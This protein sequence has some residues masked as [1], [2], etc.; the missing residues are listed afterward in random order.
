MTKGPPESPLQEPTPPEP[1]V[2]NWLS[3]MMPLYAR[4]Q[5][6]LLITST[7]TSRKTGL[8]DFEESDS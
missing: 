7:S 8:A 5:C 3:W 1:E 6:N 4:L 2:H